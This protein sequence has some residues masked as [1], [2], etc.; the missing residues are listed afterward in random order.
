MGMS[1]QVHR[2]VRKKGKVVGM[3]ATPYARLSNDGVKINVQAGQFYAEGGKPWVGEVPTWV[4]DQLGK[5]DPSILAE[6]Q[7]D[8][9]PP[10]KTAASK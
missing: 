3:R 1:L 2:P 4:Y 9:T 5:M 8:P 7:I 10:K 6:L